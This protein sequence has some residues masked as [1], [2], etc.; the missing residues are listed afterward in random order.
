MLD[1]SMRIL[2]HTIVDIRSCALYMCWCYMKV[3][4]SAGA[5]IHWDLPSYIPTFIPSR[6]VLHDMTWYCIILNHGTLPCMM[7]HCVHCVHNL[8]HHF[9]ATTYNT[10]NAIQYDTIHRT[11]TYTA[12]I[13]IYKHYDICV[14]K[15]IFTNSTN[16][17]K[18]ACQRIFKYAR[19]NCIHVYI[20]LHM[21]IMYV[22]VKIY[23]HVYMN[24]QTHTN[25]V[26]TDCFRKL[27]SFTV[28]PF[29]CQDSPAA[30]L[31]DIVLF[32]Y[33]AFEG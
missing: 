25:V 30:F 19:R 6:I 12:Y 26:H 29:Y 16:V 33:H 2:A 17:V 22:H 32:H 21:Y 18:C 7:L 24:N 14:Y 9:L 31:L 28:A 3:R 4:D 1:G 20:W 23:T 10:I 11:Y 15:C 8:S 13:Y 27:W 5:F